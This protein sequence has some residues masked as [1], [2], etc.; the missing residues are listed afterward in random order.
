MLMK[1]C[2]DKS[3][4][5]W[6]KACKFSFGHLNLKPTGPADNITFCFILDTVVTFEFVLPVFRVNFCMQFSGSC[7]DQHGQTG[8][9]AGSAW[10]CQGHGSYYPA[11]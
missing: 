11:L 9:G 5:P 7:G 1:N 8:G 4:V 6:C 3:V 10:Q 2:I